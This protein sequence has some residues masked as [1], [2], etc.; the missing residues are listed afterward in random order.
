LI[1][2]LN[3]SD[4]IFHNRSQAVEELAQELMRLEEQSVIIVDDGLG[5]D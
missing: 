5:S 1:G 4:M 2:M 3:N